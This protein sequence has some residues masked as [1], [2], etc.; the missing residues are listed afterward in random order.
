MH[1][2]SGRSLIEMMMVLALI[3]LMTI[4]SIKAYQS[5]NDQNEANKIH[6]LV[7]IASLNGL[8]KMKEKSGD[9]AWKSIG[10]EPDD[11]KCVDKNTFSFRAN[12]SVRIN[13]KASCDKVEK[14]L[15]TQWG[16][17]WNGTDTYTP[18]KDDE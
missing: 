11:Y 7:S 13:F 4:G 18:P 6:E 8:T 12:G 15:T 17:H 10:K 14:I 5:G 3:G 9:A 1:N 2:E 16:R